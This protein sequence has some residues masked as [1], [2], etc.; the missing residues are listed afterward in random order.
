[1]PPWLAGIA[2]A[3]GRKV[4][5]VG[6]AN[7]L[8]VLSFEYMLMFL[9]EYAT[10]NGDMDNPTASIPAI[11]ILMEKKHSGMYAHD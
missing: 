2:L 6:G 1:M 8:P 3:V 11:S 10:I 4:E 9:V 5:E 7:H